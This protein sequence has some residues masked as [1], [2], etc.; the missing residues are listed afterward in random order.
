MRLQWH[1]AIFQIAI[2]NES[3]GVI[4][5]DSA[6]QPRLAC[7]VAMRPSPPRIATGECAV[8]HTQLLHSALQH[9]RI[10]TL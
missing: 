2:V 10:A 8:L 6:T 7:P 9:E 5:A 1:G 4:V 3:G